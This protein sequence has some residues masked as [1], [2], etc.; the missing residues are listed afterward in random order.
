MFVE[1]QR[2]PFRM[3]TVQ[4]STVL[5]VCQTFMTPQW[6]ALIQKERFVDVDAHAVQVIEI[7]L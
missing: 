7:S 6:T 5:F 3:R 4:I 1:R 2:T